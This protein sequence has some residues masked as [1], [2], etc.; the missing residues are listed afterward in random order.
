MH[1]H[2]AVTQPTD[3]EVSLWREYGAPFNAKAAEGNYIFGVAVANILTSFPN[4]L[5]PT[6]S[7]S[8][9][10]AW[11]ILDGLY[12]LIAGIDLLVQD[13]PHETQRKI[14][15]II[16][17]FSAAQLFLFTYNPPLLN[18]INSA[19]LSGPTPLAGSAFALA[20]F[21]DLVNASIDFH[22]IHKEV[23][24]EGWLAERFAEIRH[25]EKRIAATRL[26][27]DIALLTRKKEKIM[28]DI[29]SRC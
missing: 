15:A 2:H 17:I 14:T 8:I 20:M 10:V 3:T 9:T 11:N 23:K 28:S 12:A 16:N 1:S 19:I 7:T 6:T 22:N 4:A 21:C 26:D 25:I 5:S 13:S 24:L 27:N 18:L 29:I